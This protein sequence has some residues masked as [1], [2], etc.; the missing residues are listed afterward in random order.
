MNHHIESHLD[1]KKF[2]TFRRRHVAKCMQGNNEKNIHQRD[3]PNEGS[4]N[5]LVLKL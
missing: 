4:R 3:I 2:A 1:E 5:Y